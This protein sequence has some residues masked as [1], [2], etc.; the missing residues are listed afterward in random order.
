MRLGIKD[1]D[2]VIKIM[3]DSSVYSYITDD[4]C[5]ESFTPEMA[6]TILNNPNDYVLSPNEYT[7]GLMTKENLV[8]YWV[9]TNIL[10]EGRGKIAI[11]AA[12]K[13]IKWMFDNTPCLKLNSWVPVFNRPA[14]VFAKQCGFKKEGLSE[15][16][17]MKNGKLYNQIL[18][19]LT[20]ENWECQQYRT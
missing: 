17:F 18:F 15:K 12:L 11:K 16:S 9:H 14:A 19:G 13:G 20:K 5:P 3:G 7:I 8:T 10:P 4:S 6:E 2:L 1:I